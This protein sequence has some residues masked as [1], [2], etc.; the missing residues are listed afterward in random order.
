[1][2][3]AIVESVIACIIFLAHSHPCRAP[4]YVCVSASMKLL[5]HCSMDLHNIEYWR[6]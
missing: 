4:P 3:L 6:I 5:E 2:L 1:V